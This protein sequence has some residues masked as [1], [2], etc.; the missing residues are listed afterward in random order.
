MNASSLASDWEKT[1]KDT[2][3]AA[4]ASLQSAT[5]SMVRGFANGVS[6]IALEEWTMQARQRRRRRL[7]LLTA[8][9]VGG[10]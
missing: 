8:G 3:Q 5:E 9:L 7:F 2:A 4:G 1:V 10:G 6:F